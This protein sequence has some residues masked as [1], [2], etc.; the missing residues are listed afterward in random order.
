MYDTSYLSRVLTSQLRNAYQVAGEHS[1]DFTE[2]GYVNFKRAVWTEGFR[3]VLESAK[4]F[5]EIGLPYTF[6]D[7][8]ARWLHPIVMILSADY[9][10]Q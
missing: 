7:G 4:K 3:K 8:T 10:E 1:E 5:A 6:R 9:E 2:K